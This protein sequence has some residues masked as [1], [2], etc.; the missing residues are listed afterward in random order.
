MC[1][2]YALAVFVKPLQ[3]SHSAA[4]MSDAQYGDVAAGLMLETI[5]ENIFRADKRNLWIPTGT[6]L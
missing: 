6:V 4:I 2:E 3:T 5:D 1:C